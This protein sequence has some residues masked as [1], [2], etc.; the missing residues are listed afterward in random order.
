MENLET[1]A[2]DFTQ[3]IEALKQ[4]NSLLEA[5]VQ[6]QQ[7]IFNQIKEKLG[8]VGQLETEVHN[9]NL[10]RSLLRENVELKNRLMMERLT[11]REKEVL[12]YITNG[13]TSKEIALQMEISK[14][15]VDTYRKHIQKKLKVAN[16]VELVRMAS[17][18]G[19]V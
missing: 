6:F 9:N 14:L 7:N 10:V 18:G 8:I 13:Y 3:E 16:I 11:N 4:K 19:F 1:R 17:D 15:T 5:Q 2:K 12:R